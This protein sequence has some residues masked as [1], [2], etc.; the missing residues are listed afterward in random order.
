[1]VS[2]G[3]LC[4][5]LVILNRIELT[6]NTETAMTRSFRAK[7]VWLAAHEMRLLRYS[8]HSCMNYQLRLPIAGL[9]YAHL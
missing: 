6:L 3:V 1:M 2:E 9:C 8:Y 4:L 7:W 5:C